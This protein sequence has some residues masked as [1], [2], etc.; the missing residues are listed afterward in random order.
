MADTSLFA[1]LVKFREIGDNKVQ[2]I[3][4]DHTPAL[5]HTATVTSVLPVPRK[6]NP[7]TLKTIVNLHCAKVV[8]SGKPTERN[9]PI[10][11]K[12]ETS[13]PMGTSAADQHAAMTDMGLV[14]TMVSEEVLQ[15]LFGM[16]IIPSY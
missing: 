9:V 11:V 1:K 6:G 16:G 4:G 12:L 15:K 7:G 8:D 2:Y 3:F 14:T 13:F 10:V 5:P